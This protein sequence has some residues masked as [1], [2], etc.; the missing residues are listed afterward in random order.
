MPRGPHYAIVMGS[1]VPSCSVV[2]SI[3]VYSMAPR[4]DGG[5]G[6]KEMRFSVGR[7]CIITVKYNF[8][9]TYI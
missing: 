7:H 6:E 8:H 9:T 3:E 2:P 4:N 5:E 1:I